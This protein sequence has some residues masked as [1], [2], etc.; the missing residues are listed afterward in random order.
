[1][2]QFRPIGIC[3]GGR[4]VETSLDTR[5]G[6]CHFSISTLCATGTLRQDGL[7]SSDFG[8]GILEVAR[9][10]GNRNK[11]ST[12]HRARSLD[13]L[14]NW[15]KET[16]NFWCSILVEVWAHLRQLNFQASEGHEEVVRVEWLY[17]K[18][19]QVFKCEVG[20]KKRP[21]RWKLGARKHKK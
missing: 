17:G 16:S 15:M 18:R 21:L 2:G 20:R 11:M 9:W 13:S 8:D 5:W 14:S 1:M 10:K 19:C 7:G 12:C 4:P 3:F 6:S